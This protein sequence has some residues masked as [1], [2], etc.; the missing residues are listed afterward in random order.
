MLGYC[1]CDDE[2]TIPQQ[3]T[4]SSALACR[5]DLVQLI[6]LRKMVDGQVTE[7]D[8]DLL[9]SRKPI[10]L[11]RRFSCVV[12]FSDRVRTFADDDR[13]FYA[14]VQRRGRPVWGRFIKRAYGEEA[15]SMTV[16]LRPVAETPAAVGWEVA[17]AYVGEPAPPFPGDPYESMK[18]R[19][20]WSRHALLDGGMPYRKDTVTT[21]CPWQ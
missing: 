8:C 19:E 15:T 18:S 9:E 10:V 13:I 7:V 4:I 11:T 5:F 2:S 20:Y 16:I 17:A 1:I 21:V 14:Q 6:R 12:G 3:I